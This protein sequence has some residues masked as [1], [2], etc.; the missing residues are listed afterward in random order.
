VNGA[1][2]DERKISV[3]FTASESQKPLRF[4]LW[5]LAQLAQLGGLSA[6]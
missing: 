1:V 2:G 5:V 4:S 3:R 6:S